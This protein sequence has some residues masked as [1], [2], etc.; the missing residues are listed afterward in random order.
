[1]DNKLFV[2]LL[3]TVSEGQASQRKGEENP[4]NYKETE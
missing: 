4:S 2:S 3:R 1:M